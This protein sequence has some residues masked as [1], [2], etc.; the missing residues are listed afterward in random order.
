MK[1]DVFISYRR[2]GGDMMAH[3]LYERLTERGF[4]VFQD[5]EVLRSG[6]FNTAIYEVIEQCKDVILVL[7]PNSL[8]RCEDE[9]DWVRN[10]IVFAIKNKKNIVPVMLRG[11]EWPEKLPLEM[12]EIRFYNGLAA[13]TEYFDQFLEKLETFLVSSR[14]TKEITSQKRT[15]R[16]VLLALVTCIGLLMPLII[17]WVFKADF[18]LIWRIIYFVFLLILAKILL[19]LIETRPE[20]AKRCFGTLTTE[21]LEESPDNVFSRLTSVFGRDILIAKESRPPFQS[22]YLLKR[23]ALG[24]WDGKRVNYLKLYFRRTLE[25]YDP[26]VF[27]LHA[28]SAGDEAVQM[29]TRQGFLLQS[30]PEYMDSRTD[31]LIKGNYHVFLYYKKKKLDHIQVLHCQEDELREKLLAA[32]EAVKASE[33]LETEKGDSNLVSIIILLLLIAAFIILFRSYISGLVK[34]LISLFG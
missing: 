34:W 32:D 6:K 7:P 21:D 29:L 13:N 4:S 16:W 8:E 33:I 25:W 14:E 12:A 18:G 10:E 2:D 24:T 17:T 20:I 23:M 28:L 1:Y 19:H 27:Y 22:L 15:Y 31:Y 5:I 9:N 11:F 3:I 26:S 30:T